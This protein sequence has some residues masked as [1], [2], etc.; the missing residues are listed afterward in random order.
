MHRFWPVEPSV[1]DWESIYH[2]ETPRTLRGRF[3]TQYSLAFNRGTL[4]ENNIA[5]ILQ[6]EVMESGAKQVVQFDEQEIQCRHIAAVHHAV[7]R[8]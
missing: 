8:R 3:A 4:L 5:L 7:A 2:L 6:Q 1:T